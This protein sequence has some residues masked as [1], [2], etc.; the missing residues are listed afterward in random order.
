[1]PASKERA[2]ALGVEEAASSSGTVDALLLRETVS[3]T[4]AT[5]CAFDHNV[6][7]LRMQMEGATAEPLDTSPIMDERQTTIEPLAG[8]QSTSAKYGCS[9]AAMAA[10]TATPRFAADDADQPANQLQQMG[11]VGV[12]VYC[13]PPQNSPSRG[14]P[15]I[16][17]SI[18]RGWQKTLSDLSATAEPSAC[19]STTRSSPRTSFQSAPG[20]IVPSGSSSLS[21]VS[22]PG[23]LSPM[24]RL[25]LRNSALGQAD[26]KSVLADDLRHSSGAQSTLF[27]S[28]PVQIG[29]SRRKGASAKDLGAF[30]R[31][32]A[33][34]G[35]TI[36]TGEGGNGKE[37]MRLAG[38]TGHTLVS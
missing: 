32:P 31:R 3:C 28:A 18:S 34:H 30:C 20:R 14:Q 2:G 23:S 15:P 25:A 27:P 10:S 8:V 35:V 9:C 37:A 11:A 33:N 24:G 5:D 16:P 26:V 7:A 6:A 38:V 17:L 21:P 13:S 1:M 29:F 19:S 4:A 12:Q 36:P 22:P